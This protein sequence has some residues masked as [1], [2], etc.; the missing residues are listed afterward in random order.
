V[1]HD[2]SGLGG[3][4]KYNRVDAKIYKY[5]TLADN[6]TFK[7]F[8]TGGYIAGY[9]GKDVRMSDRYYLGGANMR[10][11]ESAG[12]GARDRRT[13]DALGG[14]WMMYSGVELTFPIGLD[15]LGV[16]GRTFW[17]LGTIG[18]PDKFDEDKIAYSGKVRQSIGFG[19]DWLSPMG[20]VILDFGFPMVKTD[21]DEKEVFRLNFGT[22]L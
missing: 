15:E 16:K 13:G 19:F 20:R 6:Y 4:T 9:G 3:D 11:F 18:K 10:G 8:T 17:D 21:Y 2:I 7:I 22:S 14:N 5:Y 12:I 1:G